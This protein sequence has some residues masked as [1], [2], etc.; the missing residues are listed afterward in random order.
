M[1]EKSARWARRYNHMVRGFDTVALTVAALMVFIAAPQLVS[2]YVQ[3]GSLIETIHLPFP[4]FLFLLFLVWLGILE[5]GRFRSAGATGR[6][7]REYAVTFNSSLVT[8]LVVSSFAY[9]FRAEPSRLAVGLFLVLGLLL[10]LVGRYLARRILWRLRHLGRASQLLHL[11]GDRRSLEA[12]EKNVWETFDI[13]YRIAGRSEVS[14]AGK[15]LDSELERIA[16]TLVFKKTE[17]DEAVIVSPGL[18]SPA[19]LES[20]SEKLE[21]IP[22]QLSVVGGFD[23]LA[24]ARL[25]LSPDSGTPLLRV[26]EIELERFGRLVKRATDIVLSLG[27]LV[28]LSPFFLVVSFLIKIDSR[29]PVFFAQE[30]AGQYGKTF[31]MLKFRSMVLDAEALRPQLDERSRDAGNDVLFKSKSD[32]RVTSV[33][34]VLRRWSIDELPQLFNVL[35]GQ[36]SLVGPRPPLPAEISH[37]KS[38]AH[39]RLAAVPGM[40]GIWQISGRS[41]LSWEKSLQL[42]LE[43][44]SNWSIIGDVLILFRT[45]PAILSR[46]GAY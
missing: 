16:G 41:D 38:G 36:M 10:L 27:L 31:S 28:V 29:G 2:D 1:R 43:Y 45:I 23:E 11:I 24:L 25:K 6:G 7:F 26:R 22:L 13:G 46:R 21:L 8:F 39:F 15:G 12:F 14:S 40:T 42:D 3:G 17:V 9:L 20:F 35:V 30:R 37:Y 19:Q 34:R 32:P 33:G 18:L 5:T 44:V 4:F